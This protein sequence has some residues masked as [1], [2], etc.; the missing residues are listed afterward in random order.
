MVVKERTRSERELS[1]YTMSMLS[2][3]SGRDSR[4]NSQSRGNSQ[5]PGLDLDN[6]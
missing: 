4:N 2:Q 6:S 3:M 5:E 1:N